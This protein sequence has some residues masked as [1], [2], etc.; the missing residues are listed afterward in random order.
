MD[1]GDRAGDCVR[2]LDARVVSN[3]V[4]TTHPYGPGS[5]P[6]SCQRAEV[7]SLPYPEW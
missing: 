6:Y 2:A 7:A 4:E 5:P 3:A 1:Y